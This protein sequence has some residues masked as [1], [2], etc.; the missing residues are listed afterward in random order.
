M[1]ENYRKALEGIH[2]PMAVH[3]PLIMTVEEAYGI[4]TDYYRLNWV[5]WWGDEETPLPAGFTACRI[6]QKSPDGDYVVK[7]IEE[8]GWRGSSEHPYVVPADLL[9]LAFYGSLPDET[10]QDLFDE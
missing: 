1:H 3:Q 4:D 9:L 10:H 5:I 2:F 6:D 8:R 7:V